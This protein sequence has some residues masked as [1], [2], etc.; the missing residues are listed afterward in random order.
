MSV[1]K[2]FIQGIRGVIDQIAFRW[3]LGMTLQKSGPGP[4]RRETFG[5]GSRDAYGEFTA[6]EKAEVGASALGV[7]LLCGDLLK[8]GFGV[9][10]IWLKPNDL[11]G[12]IVDVIF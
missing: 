4:I 8:I 9:L 1:G 6:K 3:F 11:S 12:F 5:G 7:N 10:T 2:S